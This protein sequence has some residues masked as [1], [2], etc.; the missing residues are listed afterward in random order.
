MFYPA[1]FAE[2]DDPFK[3]P[4]RRE[5]EILRKRGSGWQVVSEIVL[6]QEIKPYPA[7]GT[8][9]EAVGLLQDYRTT[10]LRTLLF[11]LPGADFRSFH[12]TGCN[13]W[14]LAS[15]QR[16]SEGI[17]W[18]G[19]SPLLDGRILGRISPGEAGSFHIE[20]IAER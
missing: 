11:N 19:V 9:K 6:S 2:E 10:A 7:I 17:S 8:R 13:K 1:G 20:S 3:S 15:F 12:R 4:V 5:N 16:C 18:N 14:T